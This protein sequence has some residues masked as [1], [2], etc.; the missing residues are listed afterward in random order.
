MPAKDHAGTQG[1]QG[2]C[3]VAMPGGASGDARLPSAGSISGQPSTVH[4]SPRSPSVA[5]V[6]L[7]VIKAKAKK[8]LFFQ[9]AKNGTDIRSLSVPIF[10]SRHLVSKAN[11]STL[12][13][14]N[15]MVLAVNGFMIL[16]GQRRT[17]F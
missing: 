10:A 11:G 12:L 9:Y 8:K 13:F 7:H 2:S 16:N 1:W 14:L 17:M 6:T 3:Q 15:R 4:R 5:S